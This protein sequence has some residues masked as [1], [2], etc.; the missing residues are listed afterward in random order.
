MFS[1][2]TKKLKWVLDN[3]FITIHFICQVI[4]NMKEKSPLASSDCPPGAAVPGQEA[5]RAA[6]GSQGK[7]CTSEEA[8]PHT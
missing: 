2:Q 7:Q 3:L 6:L 1:F 4:L 5:G 8:P